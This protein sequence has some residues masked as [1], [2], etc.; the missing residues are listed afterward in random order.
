MTSTETNDLLD[1][2]AKVLLRCFLLGVLL[3]LIWFAAYTLASDVIY[4][5]GK[6][7]EL[8]PHELDLIHYC[9]MGLVK[10]GVF[11]F[12]LLPYIGIRLVLRKRSS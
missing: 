11:L 4:R 6:M 8:T 2:V 3:L 5:Q 9:G 1:A 10:G 12:F 7:F